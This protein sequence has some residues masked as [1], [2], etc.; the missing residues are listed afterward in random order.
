VHDAARQKGEHASQHKREN[1]H[2]GHCLPVAV[3]AMVAGAPDG[4]RQRGERENRKQVDRAPNAQI[5]SV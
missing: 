1:E 3:D 4:K 2:A 5:F